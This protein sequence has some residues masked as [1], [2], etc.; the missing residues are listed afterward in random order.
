[1]A[2]AWAA[3][4]VTR[5]HPKESDSV[6]GQ[7]RDVGQVMAGI[8]KQ[9]KGVGGQS[10]GDLEHDDENVQTDGKPEPTFSTCRQLA[11]TDAVSVAVAHVRCPV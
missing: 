8:R 7:G 10:V 11:A 1:M 9:P 4:T 5:C 3:R 2:F 6:A